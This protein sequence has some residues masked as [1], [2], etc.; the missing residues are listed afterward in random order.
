MLF[1]GTAMSWRVGWKIRAVP[2]TLFLS[3]HSCSGT[4]SR[5]AGGCCELTLSVPWPVVLPGTPLPP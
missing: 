4:L 5:G 2:C 3:R 1:C